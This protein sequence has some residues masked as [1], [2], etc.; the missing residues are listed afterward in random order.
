MAAEIILSKSPGTVLWRMETDFWGKQD[1]LG[2]KLRIAN[3]DWASNDNNLK[4][5]ITAR[6]GDILIH[7]QP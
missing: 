4:A 5:S 3:K 1:V 2:K 7:G 6:F